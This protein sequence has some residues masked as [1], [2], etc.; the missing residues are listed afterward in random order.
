MDMT[1][2]EMLER[3]ARLFPEKTA[4]IYGNSRISYRTFYERA[5][6]LANFL[7]A[8]GLK[9]GDRV[10]LMLQK[11][12]EVLISFLGVAAAGGIVFPVDYNQTLDSID[13][14]LNLTNPTVVIADERFQ[15]LLSCFE[16]HCSDE[17][18]IV[19][20][21]KTTNQRRSWEEVFA[22]QSLNPPGVEIQDSDVVYLN[23]T[24][25]TTGLP[26]GASTTH[27]NIYWNTRSA[28][29]SLGLTEEDIHLCMFPV[30]GHPHEL[31]ARS[32]YLGG[33][34]VLI[35]S[36]YPKSI[37]MAI[38][39]YRV[40]CMMAVASIYDTLARLPLSSPFDLSSL[41]IPESG[42]MYIQPTLEQKFRER[43]K[44]PIIPVWGSTETSGIALVIPVEG[45]HRSGSMG[46]PSLYYQVKVMGESGEELPPDEVGEMAVKGPGVC[47][48]YYNQPEETEIYMRDGW[49]LTGDMVKMDSEGYYYFASRK[50]GMMKV[51]GLKVFPTEIEDVLI[52]HPKIEAVAVVKVQDSL[53][54]EVPKAVIVVKD[55]LEISKDEIRKYCE[56]KM[57]RYK[58]PRI[59]EFRNEL[60]KTPG[61]KI[62]YREL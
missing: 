52:N 17:K 53:H 55:G 37:A 60:P 24:S 4:I 54:G 1:I 46:K 21:Q 16:G 38:S 28:V 5:N 44:V 7:I 39:E 2:V 29:E 51:A 58:I 41:R 26:K 47:I 36:T 22:Q 13:C 6:T 56:E 42:G 33:T 31:F 32:L 25:G 9:K 20:G 8:M 57:S 27:A 45:E 43:F 30:F 50:T 12:P 62:L 35:D 18:T 48:G 23:F 10:G 34:T 14:M 40:T 15:E 61:G 11:T 59:V 19:I 49:F 3:N